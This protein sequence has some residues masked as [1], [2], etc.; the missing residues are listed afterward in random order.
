MNLFIFHILV[1]FIGHRTKYSLF[2]PK[3][4]EEAGVVISSQ[5]V[6]VRNQDMKEKIPKRWGLFFAHFIFRDK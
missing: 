2:P 1:P 3:N 4:K 5:N 6:A